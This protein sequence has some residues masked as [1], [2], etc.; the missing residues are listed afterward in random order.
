MEALINIKRK[1]Y[2]HSANNHSLL[3][4]KKF[5]M[6]VDDSGVHIRL[7]ANFLKTD[8]HHV[9]VQDGMLRLKVKRPRSAYDFYDNSVAMGA[10]EKDFDLKIRLPDKRHQQINSVRF[11]NGILQ[12]HLVVKKTIDNAKR[13]IPSQFG[14]NQLIAS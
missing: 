7:S 9:R 2:R 13:T 3:R 4:F 12:V 8:N 11:K 5:Q 14:S 10:S 1:N 6:N